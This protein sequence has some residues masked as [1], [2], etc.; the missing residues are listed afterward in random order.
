MNLR[1]IVEKGQKV[2]KGQVLCEGFAT[3]AGELALGQ[4]LTESYLAELFGFSK[5]MLRAIKDT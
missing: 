4:Q 5:T 3:Q 2:E 1:P